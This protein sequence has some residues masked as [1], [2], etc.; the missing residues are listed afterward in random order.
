MH[1]WFYASMHLCIYAFC[2]YASMRLCVYASVYLSIHPSLPMEWT[3]AARSAAEDSSIHLYIFTIAISLRTSELEWKG[4]QLAK[5]GAGFRRLCWAAGL[6]EACA[7]RSQTSG[8]RRQQKKWKI[9]FRTKLWQFIVFTIHLSNWVVCIGFGA[10]KGLKT[11]LWN[12]HFIDSFMFLD[13]LLAMCSKYYIQ[14]ARLLVIHCLLIAYW[15]P[16]DCPWC[17][18]VQP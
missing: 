10:G 16:I 7:Q 18:Y 14:S 2:I 8:F 13:L 5:V 12:V 9:Q 1:L 6:P 15:L 17:T 4:T 11:N 3:M